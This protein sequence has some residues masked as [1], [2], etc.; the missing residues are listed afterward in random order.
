MRELTKS[1]L[2][3]SW[4]MSL[5]GV[6][7][8]ANVLTPDKAAASFNNVTEAAR[9]ELGESTEATFKAGD[10]LQRS[11]VDLTFGVFS[12]QAFNPSK[13]AKATSGVVQQAAKATSDVAQQAVGAVKQVIPATDKNAKS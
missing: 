10:N 5:F 8:A 12:L 3:F 11:L 1:I 4:A 7:Q 2:S 9:E 6:R 13:W